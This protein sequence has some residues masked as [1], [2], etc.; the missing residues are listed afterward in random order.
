MA[1]V[2][3]K[4]PEFLFRRYTIDPYMLQIIWQ[5]GSIGPKFN[6]PKNKTAHPAWRI[7]D[8]VTKV[9]PAK[10][11]VHYLMK[12]QLFPLVARDWRNPLDETGDIVP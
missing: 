3:W 8:Q 12:L 1:A 6:H 9:Y 7:K 5:I 11:K 10:H 2:L 4:R